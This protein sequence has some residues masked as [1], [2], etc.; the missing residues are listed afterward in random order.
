M[1]YG[2]APPLALPA[3]PAD[4]AEDVDIDDVDVGVGIGD[5]AGEAMVVGVDVDVP[6]AAAM[7]VTSSSNPP[8]RENVEDKEEGVGVDVGIT[9]GVDDA[10]CDCVGGH[11]PC[12]DAY[13]RS[14]SPTGGAAP[15]SE[16]EE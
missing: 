3:V 15:G 13:S 10:G 11:R 14:V 5:V 12:E 4:A 1:M 16:E 9:K 6:S 2:F 7:P 8:V